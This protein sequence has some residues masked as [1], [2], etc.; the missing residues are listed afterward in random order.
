VIKKGV[1]GYNLI[2]M[3]DAGSFLVLNYNFMNF[4]LMLHVASVRSQVC[5]LLIPKYGWQ[6]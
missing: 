3:H 4:H 6:D 2:M 1:L 5:R